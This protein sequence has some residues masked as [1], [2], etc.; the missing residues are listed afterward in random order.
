MDILRKAARPLSTRRIGEAMAEIK[1]I[2]VDGAE[3]WDT[4]LKPVLGAARRLE[5]KGTIKMVGRVDGSLCGAIIWAL[6]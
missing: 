4:F 1:N 2:E 6:P 5:Q 3:A